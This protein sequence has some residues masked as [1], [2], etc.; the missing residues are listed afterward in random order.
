MKS[1]RKNTVDPRIDVLYS[2]RFSL[3]MYSLYKKAKHWKRCNHY[4]VQ[5]L[6]QER[7]SLYKIDHSMKKRLSVLKREAQPLQ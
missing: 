5:K 7:C 1:L 2:Y 4:K 6:V 3:K